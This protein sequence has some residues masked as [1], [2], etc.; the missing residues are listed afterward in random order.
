MRRGVALLLASLLTGGCGGYY[1]LTVPDQVAPAG[2]EAV[3]V[4][5]LQR[6]D[7][8]FVDVAAREAAI[9]FKVADCRERGAYTDKI[10]YAGAAV[11]VPAD[12]GRYEMVVSH[13]DFEGEEVVANVP[14]YVW[15]PAKVVVAV[16][17]DSLPRS[18]RSFLES[19]RATWSRL[20]RGMIAPP[21]S[22]REAVAAARR[23][24]GRVAGGANVLYLT[25]EKVAAHAAMHEWLTT[26][27]YPDG[28][29]LLWQRQRWHIVRQGRFRI[30]RVVIE[31]RLVSQLAEL[32]KA[33]PKMGLGITATSL[34]SRSFAEAGLRCVV[35][36][37]AKA[38][39]TNPIRFASWQ[40]LAEKGL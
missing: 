25:R 8:L 21:P 19:T 3:A 37:G 7:F 30:P 12:V 15:D 33:F 24:L 23:A 9:Q 1:T 16:D 26:A 5:R 28:P 13:L 40:A 38:H 34:A 29:I 18:G 39:A 4:A 6:N 2:G 22:G 36:G 17:L 14:L 35:I 32:R 27:G 31:A 10:G 11:P 20:S